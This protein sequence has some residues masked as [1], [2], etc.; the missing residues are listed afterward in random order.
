MLRLLEDKRTEN[1]FYNE[2]TAVHL[3]SME[4]LC[5]FMETNMYL[6]D[7]SWVEEE[8]FG[9]LERELGR[10]KLAADLRVLLRTKRDA[11]ACAELIF[12]ESGLY[13]KREMEQIRAMLEQMKGRTKMERRKMSGDLF[14]EEGRYRQAAYIYLEL[15]EEPY[16][17]QMTEEL[18]GNICHNLGVVYAR[19]FFF[20]EAAECFAKAYALHKNPDSRD[21][22][23]YAMNYVEDD[24][25]L[26]ESGMELNFSVMRD[27]LAHLTETAEQ[28]E[29]YLDR[30]SASAAAAACD[31][32]SARESLIS[33]WISDYRRMM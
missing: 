1:A 22:Y 3:Y 33:G 8:L 9:W 11:F 28:P 13:A 17:R 10:A 25:T 12:S 16:A 21:A 30:K 20:P 14:L 4:E 31:W 23:L 19:L 32:K 15:L 27:A 7:P 5:F 24:D 18:R 6:I 29:Y 26:K 2:N